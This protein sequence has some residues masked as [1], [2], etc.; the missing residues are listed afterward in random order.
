[1][2]VFILDDQP[3]RCEGLKTLLRQIDRHANFLQAN[4]W[5]PVLRTLKFGLPD[6]LIMDW[7]LNWINAPAVIELLRIYPTLQIAIFTEDLASMDMSQLLQ[8]GVLGIIPRSLDPRHALRALELVLL[9]GRYIPCAALNLN[10]PTENRSTITSMS[11]ANT[12]AKSPSRQ[13]NIKGVS[14]LS[15]RQHQIIRFLHMG[16]TNK[17]VARALDISEGTVKIHLSTIYRL[18]GATNRASAVAFYNNWQFEYQK[19]TE[20][21]L[22]QANI[23]EDKPFTLSISQ[24]ASE[25]KNIAPPKS[26]AALLNTIAENDSRQHM[27][28]QTLQSYSPSVPSPLDTDEDEKE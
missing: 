21:T 14:R 15:P 22:S 20:P 27:I 18:L 5:K 3:E 10:L 6:L 11:N 28:A 1:M 24:T 4:S 19:A 16:N 17:M 26:C 13:C 25:L 7:Q 2:K 12:L 8:A 9:G 23:T